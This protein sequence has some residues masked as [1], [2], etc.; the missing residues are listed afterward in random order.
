MKNSLPKHVRCFFAYAKTLH[1]EAFSSLSSAGRSELS[2]L[3]QEAIEEAID[4]HPK[5]R[6]STIVKLVAEQVQD[7]VDEIMV[8]DQDR[9]HVEKI[10]DAAMAIFPSA[11]DLG[12]PD[13]ARLVK[14]A[15][16]VRDHMEEVAR[17]WDLDACTSMTK[18]VGDLVEE[19][20][21]RATP[22]IDA[23]LRGV[24]LNEDDE[25]E[26]EDCDA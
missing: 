11:Y 9:Q 18:V 13:E 23:L 15:G 5:A 7:E 24:V 2:N 22:Q 20:T 25:S 6:I 8:G 10:I 4:D 3:V 19:A 21:D 12:E 26:E 17:E 14:I 1:P 16:V